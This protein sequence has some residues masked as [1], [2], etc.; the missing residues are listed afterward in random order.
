MENNIVK[1][2]DKDN[3]LIECNVIAV[4]P[5]N[6]AS[7]IIYKEKNNQSFNSGLLASKIKSFDNGEYNLEP[8]TKDEWNYIEKEYNLLL[9]KIERGELNG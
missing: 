5:S 3:N 4:I 6:N 8:L 9:E 2:L 7:Y 1:F